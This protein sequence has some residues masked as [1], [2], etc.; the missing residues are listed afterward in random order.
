M[1]VYK[2]LVKYYDAIY[3]DAWENDIEFYYQEAKQANGKIL[4]IGCGTGRILLPLVKKNID[5]I[6]LDISK[7]MIN[8]LEKNAKKE[9][10]NPKVING[11]MKN[12]SLNEKFDLV[13]IP[14]RAFLHMLTKEDQI[15]TLKNI[16]KHLNKNGKLI[17]HSYRPYAKEL[18]CTGKCHSI[19]TTEHYESESKKNFFVYWDLEYI[20]EKKILKYYL[21]IREENNKKETTFPM[22]IAHITDEDMQD[23][24]ENSGFSKI[25]S[26]GD[27]E[28]API[29]KDS[30]EIIYI[31]Q[32]A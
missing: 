5:I 3:G 2:E 31:A 16:A 19:D 14:Y 18:A 21:R 27:F 32:L 29:Y 6:G 28:Y 30:T 1:T 26:Y 13:I 15:K 11:D 23:N 17:I 12:F 10:L 20:K 4:E 25:K 7:E 22:F 9:N 8:V 24:L